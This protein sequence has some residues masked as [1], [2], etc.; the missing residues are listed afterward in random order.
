MYQQC[1]VSLPTVS[2]AYEALPQTSACAYP[3]LNG[4]PDHR[5]VTYAL[6]SD[7][8][9]P[10]K[11]GS[12]DER[13]PGGRRQLGFIAQEVEDVAP[14][15]VAEDGNGYK[16][17]AYSRLVPTLAAALSSALERLDRLEGPRS[18]PLPATSSESAPSSSVTAAT[19]SATDEASR[20]DPSVVAPDGG[21]Q[22]SDYGAP[23]HAVKR[24]GRRTAVVGGDGRQAAGGPDSEPAVFDLRQ[25]WV[26]NTAL[27]GRVGE[28]EKRMVELE[29]KLEAD[30]LVG[31]D[32]GSR[33]SG[34]RLA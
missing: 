27:R 33:G 20:A 3:L 9:P 24:H 28:M 15:V 32:K 25:L 7:V 14:E 4:A 18:T 10:S 8:I 21:K 12:S 2:C 34:V 11:A 19:I 16:T 6:K 30:A 13:A 22:F 26:E 5:A 17:V 29:R 23:R 1:S 31:A